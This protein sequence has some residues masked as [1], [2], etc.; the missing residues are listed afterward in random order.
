MKSLVI[1]SHVQIGSG[2]TWDD[3]Q[4]AVDYEVGMIFERAAEA[5]IDR[6]CVAAV[7]NM[8]YSDQNKEVARL[9]EKYP[10]DLIGF[11]V[12]SPQREAGE[13]RSLLTEEVKSMGLKGVKSDGHPTRELL[14]VAAELGIPVMYYPKRDR[15]SGLLTAFH[16]MASAYPSVNFILPHL[17]AF[18]SDSYPTHIEAIDLVKRHSNMHVE[19]SG[20]PEHKYLEMAARELPAEKIIFGSFAPE[21]DPRVGIHAIRLLKLE[22][23][24]ENAVLGGNIRRLLHL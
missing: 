14:D 3:P 9:C 17:G 20:I 7:Q 12:H 24:Q 22:T 19:T 11:A 4:R 8:T 2:Q 10:D 13:L 23:E 5:G 18:R 1:D 15:S 6:C 16:M 21:L